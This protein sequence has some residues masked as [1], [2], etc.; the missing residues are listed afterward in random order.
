MYISCQVTITQAAWDQMAMCKL[1]QDIII[2]NYR[3][4]Y[5]PSEPE[6]R[7]ISLS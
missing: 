5:S 3:W 7:N 1:S 4:W 6:I 2:M